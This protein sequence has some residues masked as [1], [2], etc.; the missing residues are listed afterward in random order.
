MSHHGWEVTFL[1][2]ESSKKLVWQFRG[3]ILLQFWPILVA[4]FVL[5]FVCVVCFCTSAILSLVT[6]FCYV[7]F[8][9]SLVFFVL[10]FNVL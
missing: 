3:A 9:F 1:P 4:D 7:S 10:F 6:L 5:C 2:R 8:P